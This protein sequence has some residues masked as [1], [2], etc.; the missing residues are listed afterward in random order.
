MDGL[1]SSETNLPSLLA[2]IRTRVARSTEVLILP[3]MLSGGT[4]SEDRESR[5]RSRYAIESALGQSGYAPE[6]AERIG[7]VRVPWLTTEGINLVKM[8]SECFAVEELSRASSV[9][10][11][12]S[13]N[14]N[15][16]PLD[17]RF[18]WHRPKVFYPGAAITKK[19][20]V[21]VL[22]L[23]DSFFEDEPLLRLP[24]LL[25]PMMKAASRTNGLAPVKLIGPRRSSTLRSML[26]SWST[27]ELSLSNDFPNLW[28]KI[29]NVFGRIDLYSATASAMDE[30]FVRTNLNGPPRAHLR[31]ALTNIGFKS[32]HNFAATD[33]QLARE[34]LAE[35]K[36]RGAEL[37]N[38]NNHL[39]LI[40]EWDTFY[41]R[42]LS[43]TYAAELA[44]DQGTSSNRLDFVEGYIK[45]TKS[46][47]TNFHS[48]VYLRGLDGQTVGGAEPA[49]T[50]DNAK[51]GRAPIGDL[52]NWAPDANKAEGQAQ[53]DY[54]GRLGDRIEKLQER[55]HRGDRGRIKAIGVVGSDV[56][57]TLLILQALRPRFPDVLFFTTDLDA[58]Y[59]HPREQAWSR[60]LI[61]ASGYDLMLHGRLQR[62]VPPFRDSSQTAQFA[63]TLAALGNTNLLTLTNVQPRRFEIGKHGAVSLRT[64][65]RA[66]TMSSGT[67]LHPELQRGV[68]FETKLGTWIVCPMAIFLATLFLRPL[69]KL[70]WESSRFQAEALFYEEEDLGGPAG[71]ESLA[72][73]LHTWAETRHDLLAK[74]L[75]QEASSGPKP[76]MGS[77]DT[78]YSVRGWYLTLLDASEKL[79]SAKT[80]EQEQSAKR[81]LETGRQKLMRCFIGCL[82]K[83]LR[84][85]IRIP[86]D[87]IEQTDLL[88]RH[89]KTAYGSWQ[90]GQAGLADSPEQMRQ[91]REI[92]DA[93]LQKLSGERGETNAS[94]QAD[95][96]GDIL[97]KAGAAREAGLELHAVRQ[98]WVCHFRILGFAAIVLAIALGR[99]IWEDFFSSA[100]GEPFSL[101]TGTSAWPAEIIRLAAFV[102]ACGF[103]IQSYHNLRGAL[104]ALTRRFRLPLFSPASCVSE[105]PPA[106]TGAR[107]DSARAAADDLRSSP[108][109]M[110]KLYHRYR[111]CFRLPDWDDRSAIDASHLWVKY[112][113]LGGFWRRAG[114][115][116][117][118]LVLYGVLCFGIWKMSGEALMRPLRGAAAI[119][120]DLGLLLATSAGFLILTFITIDAAL[121]CRWFIR[122]L[123]ETPTEYPLASSAYFSRLRGNVDKHYLDEWI[124]LQLIADLTER[125]GK[126]VYYP[127]A[128]FFLLLLARNEWW[129]H[130]NWP[131][132]LISIYALNLTL[133]AASVVILQNAARKAKAE[134]E[135][136]LEAKVKQLQAAAA[137]SET[138]NNASQAE[139][140]LEEVRNLR[141]GAF[142]PFWE[143]PVLGAILLPSGGTAF[144]QMLVWFMGR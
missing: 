21:L 68:A 141:R 137:E 99:R 111:N 138:K 116:A 91:G 37:T 26:P 107:H 124:D 125:V 121:L 57:D 49:G 24:M 102:L 83:L 34:I 4:Y 94:G 85:Q 66:N 92:L 44:R 90:A 36:L 127:S 70:T 39:V 122:R 115:I 56:Y 88:S 38:T 65:A 33:D 134:A 114:R 76:Q 73:C 47:P 140:L 1:D 113:E 10:A 7:W 13:V 20:S 12:S 60:N 135:A 46:M 15:S 11:A 64:D 16:T 28:S 43:L 81:E 79:A 2:Q 93:L 110:V 105:Q 130:W 6:D 30:T 129:D 118:P 106:T 32:F 119:Q 52:P 23:N 75:L 123:S 89:L 45:G 58:R 84:R 136:T 18:E 69:R 82:N 22:W 128:I 87:G 143:S 112:R 67:K 8:N 131:W 9:E 25:E 35:L 97:N 96:P 40:S 109:T 41:A 54:L 108:V 142:V 71:A 78:T 61:V 62:E 48:Y 95:V 63:A 27:Q 117:G 72:S 104:F 74:W 120:W 139:R 77:Y 98:R 14:E 3:V 51:A 126:L 42:M 132:W 53:F 31:T 19:P 55:F 86:D 100:G 17:L 59:W 80:P 103:I 101:T 5:I 50:E 133:A 144:L 29:T